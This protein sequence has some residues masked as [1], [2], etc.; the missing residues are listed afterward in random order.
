MIRNNPHSVDRAYKFIYFI[1]RIIFHTYL[2]GEC[3]KIE[4]IE[5]EIAS[6]GQ[7][8]DV[9]VKVDDDTIQIT[10]LM[11][12]PLNEEKL[13]AMFDYHE[14]AR[15][16]PEYKG[17]NIKTG[18]FSI[19][20]PTHGISMIEIDDNVTFYVDSKF[21]K[22]KDMWKVLNTLN[23]KS[24]TQKKLSNEEAVDLLVLP[25]M[26]MR[27]EEYKEIPIEELMRTVI[28]L[29]GNVKY[30]SFDLKEKI[31]ICEIMVLARF[32]TGAKLIE[33]INMLKTAAKN[34]EIVQKMQEY[35]PGF[36][37]IY[38]NGREDE[39][40]EKNIEH[41][42][43]LLEHGVDEKTIL[44]CIDISPEELEKIKRKL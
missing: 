3:E 12:T 38:L 17:Y 9:S 18:V 37:T 39:R 31:F 41:T 22:C 13:R 14:S 44:E 21:A 36:H 33:M 11:A 42:R 29:M 6:T 35:G 10:E 15:R 23:H 5:T 25:D 40:I 27:K 20:E 19:A 24:F 2:Y 8:K 16:N 7:R 28:V 34:P 32:F 1:L 43:N 30:P 26:N 4:F